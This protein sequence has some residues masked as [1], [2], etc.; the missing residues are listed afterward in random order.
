MDA[1][2]K[3]QCVTCPPAKTRQAVRLIPSF[4][5][6]EQKKN[7]SHA[8]PSV[9]A[10][11]MPSGSCSAAD[12]NAKT[13]GVCDS[14]E[15]GVAFAAPTAL[16]KD[17]GGESGR[18]R[19]ERVS[20]PAH[21]KAEA[22]AA[23]EAA[24]LA[25]AIRA[26]PCKPR[27]PKLMPQPHPRPQHPTNSTED[28]LAGR[29]PWLGLKQKAVAK[30]SASR[31]TSP[32]VSSSA[33][34]GREQSREKV[35]S[36]G[37]PEAATPAAPV[38][39]PRNQSVKREGEQSEKREELERNASLMQ[40]PSSKLPS[41][42]SRVRT[43]TDAGPTQNSV[44]QLVANLEI[45]RSVP[46]L[47]GSGPASAHAT[48]EVTGR[49]SGVK[50]AGM[51]WLDDDSDDSPEKDDVIALSKLTPQALNAS[52]SL[53][54]PSNVNALSIKDQRGDTM[55]TPATSE[56]T[57]LRATSEQTRPAFDLSNSHD[58]LDSHSDDDRPASP[59]SQP[60]LPVSNPHQDM[61]ESYSTED[62]G[63]EIRSQD[64]ADT[65]EG[66]ELVGGEDDD[67]SSDTSES[68][69]DSDSDADSDLPM[70]P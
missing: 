61:P 24:A 16:G 41:S 31:L 33:T 57:N 23:A 36:K 13:A 28:I 39:H 34:V 12:E 66:A 3:M 19:R 50:I 4:G 63:P 70:P 59:V 69:R 25:A 48:D 14:S 18:M 49:E 30:K 51:A 47:S 5:V 40:Q 37:K 64:A 26:T 62:E 27:P 17:I 42:S 20:I 45:K 6:Q 7:T 53:S 55:H 9:P 11:N 44:R 68:V 52:T 58:S 43:G 60:S 2:G 65:D 8:S 10:Q 46:A 1:Y 35:G 21:K 38:A 67:E 32:S 15:A 22:A 29:P 56:Q 54:A